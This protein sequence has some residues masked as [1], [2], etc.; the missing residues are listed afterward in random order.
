MICLDIPVPQNCGDCPCA[1]IFDSYT[2]MA[3]KRSFDKYPFRPI[4]V[5]GSEYYIQ[6]YEAE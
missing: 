6:E 5:L 3:A 2:C 1:R 4:I